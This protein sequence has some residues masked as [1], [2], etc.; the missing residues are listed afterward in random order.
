MLQYKTYDNKSNA[1]TWR[2][3][4]TTESAAISLARTM[5]NCFGVRIIDKPYKRNDGMWV[6]SFSNPLMSEDV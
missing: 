1:V 2:Y 5:K 4:A 3:T 6:F